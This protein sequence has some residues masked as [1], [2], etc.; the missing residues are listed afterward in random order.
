M[1][2]VQRLAQ[3]TVDLARAA[4]VRLAGHM[5][6]D[7]NAHHPLEAFDCQTATER[8]ARTTAPPV[9][10]WIQIGMDV[11]RSARTAVPP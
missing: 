7:A 11:R 9:T 1:R 3:R 2:A 8:R 6:P 10:T 4:V 5:E